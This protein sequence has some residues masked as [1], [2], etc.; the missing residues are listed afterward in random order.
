L[1][2]GESGN[3]GNSEDFQKETAQRVQAVYCF[4]KFSETG[5]LKNEKLRECQKR[6]WKGVEGAYFFNGTFDSSMIPSPK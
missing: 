3:T 6:Y 5:D 1:S 4:N 2:P